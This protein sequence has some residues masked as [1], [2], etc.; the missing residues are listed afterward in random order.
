MKQEQINKAY[1]SLKKLCSLNLPLKKAHAVYKMSKGIDDAFQFAADEERKY[2]D[3]FGGKIHADGSVHFESVEKCDAFKEKV[4]ELYR[5]E[6]D[7]KFDP[8]KL[9]EEDLGRQTIAPED[10]A[11]LEGFV[12]FE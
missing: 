8:V 6:L 12:L 9:T 3:E 1:P 7:I 10:I 5:M 4:E 11:N 2:I